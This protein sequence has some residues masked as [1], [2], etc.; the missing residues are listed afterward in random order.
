MPLEKEKPSALI[1][2]LA[3]I[4]YTDEAG[5]T[6]NNLFDEAQPYFWTGTLF[7]QE[8]LSITGVAVHRDCL[9]ASGIAELHGSALG[10]SGI[11]RI[12]PCLLSFLAEHSL[13]FL[14]TRIEKIHL[15]ATKFA[16]TLLD[17]GVNPDVPVQQYAI[18]MLRIMLAGYLESCLDRNDLEETA[19]RRCS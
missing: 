1:S 9:Q 14:F 12:A 2:Q 19:C 17:T 4:A 8:D 11:D 15:A 13:Q 16:D 7:A 6:G 3:W 10:L 5:N 18:K